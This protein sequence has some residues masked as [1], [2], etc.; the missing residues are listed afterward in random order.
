MYFIFSTLLLTGPDQTGTKRPFIC[1]RFRP[2]WLRVLSL[3]GESFYLACILLS[4]CGSSQALIKQEQN[5]LSSN[6]GC[7][8]CDYMRFLY[9][10]KFLQHVF[11]MLLLTGLDQ[12]ECGAA[13]TQSRCQHL[14]SRP[15]CGRGA[16]K[17]QAATL[18][19][20]WCWP[21]AALQTS[22]HCP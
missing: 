12:T 17:S 3:A 11:S 1:W 21:A 13:A 19:K 6:G 15:S 4:P 8:H 14:A 9:W 10:W 2:Q 20:A 5:I 22:C 18:P 16:R 7:D